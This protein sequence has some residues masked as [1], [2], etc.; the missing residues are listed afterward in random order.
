MNDLVSKS[1]ELYLGS[2][3]S[4]MAHLGANSLYRSGLES[5]QLLLMT[6][7]SAHWLQERGW[8]KEAVQ[9]Y[10]F[11]T[12]RQPVGKL[13]DRGGWGTTPM[14]ACVDPDD[15][16]CMAPIVSGPDDILLVIAGGPGRH[17][18]AILNASYNLSVTKP[19]LRKNG[20]PLR[21]VREF[22]S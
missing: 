1:P 14:A 9:R 22:L 19:I 5:E 10:L 11:E 21:S 2:A 8:G 18:N 12:A 20:A 16:D 3:A 7:E 17:M 6:A 4:A 15:D 13:R